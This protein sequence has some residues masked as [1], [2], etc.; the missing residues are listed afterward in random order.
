MIIFFILHLH[1]VYKHDLVL[2][3]PQVL[4]FHKIKQTKTKQIENFIIVTTNR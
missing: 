4:I 2:N 1:P 3:Y